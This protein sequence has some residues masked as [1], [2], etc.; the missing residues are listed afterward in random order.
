MECLGRKRLASPFSGGSDGKESACNAGDLGLIP[1]LERFPGKGN[2]YPLQCSCLENFKNRG[3]WRATVHGVAK[4]QTWR[5]TN[6]FTLL[7]QCIHILNNYT[8]HFKYITA[9]FVKYTSIKLTKEKARK[10]RKE[11]ENK[12]LVKYLFLHPA[13]P[14]GLLYSMSQYSSSYV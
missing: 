2:G 6:T 5:A 14:F 7:S 12:S 8:A 13:V 11:K 10:Q 4:S 9:L 3:A 1:G